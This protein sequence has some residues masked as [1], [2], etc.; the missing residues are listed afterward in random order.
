MHPDQ[1]HYLSHPRF[2]ACPWPLLPVG[3]RLEIARYLIDG[4]VLRPFLRAVAAGDLY[5]AQALNPEVDLRPFATFFDAMPERSR[6]SYVHVAQW[7]MVGGVSGV[8]ELN[9][10]IGRVYL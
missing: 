5:A 10:N 9:E 1:A 8:H 2:C 6:G 7:E 4:S 3:C